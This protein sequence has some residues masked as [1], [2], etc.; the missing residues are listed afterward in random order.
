MP[1]YRT[2]FGAHLKIV[3]IRAGVSLPPL[4][5]LSKIKQRRSKNAKS[6]KRRTFQH[7]RRFLQAAK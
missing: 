4:A 3:C 7:V 5:A 6:E 1:D 2:A